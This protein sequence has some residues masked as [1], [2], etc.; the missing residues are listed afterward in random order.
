MKKIKITAI[1]ATT[2]LLAV[3]LFSIAPVDAQVE[4]QFITHRQILNLVKDIQTKVNSAL[5]LLQDPN[6]GL[7]EIKNEEFTIKTL[8]SGPPISFDATTFPNDVSVEVRCSE[9][10]KSTRYVVSSILVGTAHDNA[11]DDF[12]IASN[13]LKYTGTTVLHE[14]FDPPAN[15]N[16]SIDML[17][18]LVGGMTS[19]FSVK[20]TVTQE[21]G[22]GSADS[23]K[24]DV[25]ILVPNEFKDTCTM[26]VV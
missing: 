2:A 12:K 24:I 20:V 6:F 14:G 18:S 1:I 4:A 7:Q 10:F 8:A 19:A 13:S 23:V 26:E 9:P 3:F 16:I 22:A 11:A 21:A 5:A 15:T 17:P 25:T